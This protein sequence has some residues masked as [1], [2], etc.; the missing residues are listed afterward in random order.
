PA[1]THTSPPSL[2][3]ALPI[4][5]TV[6][7]KR[8]YTTYREPSHAVVVKKRRAGVAVNTGVSTRTSVRS[9]T[10]GSA[11]VRGSST[12]RT[13]GG[14]GA[15]VDRKSTRLNSSHRTTSYA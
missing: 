4:W 3:D 11:T 6:I 10:V 1:P 8:R 7:K 2:H 14:T 15:N 12:T 5:T 13:S 9:R